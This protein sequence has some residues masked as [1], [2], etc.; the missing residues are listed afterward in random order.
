MIFCP[1]VKELERWLDQHEAEGPG[2]A[3]A[4]HVE[5]CAECQASVERLLNETTP[6]GI[7]RPHDKSLYAAID[8]CGPLLMVLRAHPPGKGNSDGTPLW[9]YGGAGDEATPVVAGYEVLEEI[10]R[11]GMGVVYRARHHSLNRFVALKLIRGGTALEPRMQARFHAEAKAAA[12]LQHPN[13]IQVHEIG[14]CARGPYL[15]LEFVEGGSL[16]GK[17]KG[18]PQPVAE[19]ADMVATLA[20]AIHYAHEQGIIHRDLKPANVLMCTPPQSATPRHDRSPSSSW[21]SARFATLPKI[22]DFGLARL[23]DDQASHSI[24]NAIVGTPSYMAP[25]QA[26]CGLHDAGAST[27]IYSLGAILYEMLTGRPPF[28]GKTSFDTVL[29][30]QHE[31]PIAPRRIRPQLPLDLQTICLKCLRKEPDKRYSSAADVA[32]DLERFLVGRPILARPV[33]RVESCWR[34]CRRNPIVASL[35]VAL[36]LVIVFG[37]VGVSWKW[38]ESD[39]QRRRAM[40]LAEAKDSALQR[41]KFERREKEVALATARINLYFH[42]IALAH[43]EWQANNLAMAEKILDECPRDLRNWEWHYLK[44]RCH[45]ET[46]VLRECGDSVQAIAFSPDGQRLATAAADGTVVVW[47]ARTRLRIHT[48][49]GK[50]GNFSLLRFNLDGNRL[51]RVSK[52]VIQGAPFASDTNLTSWDTQTGRPIFDIANPFV[53]YKLALNNDATR[54]AVVTTGGTTQLW[55]IQ[56]GTELAKL[57]VRLAGACVP[58]ISRDGNLI[59]GVSANGCLLVSSAADGSVVREL[60]RPAQRIV[61]VDF[62]PDGRRLADARDQSVCLWDV[63][64]GRKISETIEPS[65]GIHSVQFAAAGNWLLVRSGRRD[66][67]IQSTNPP[68]K[69]EIART[70]TPMVTAAAVNPDGTSVAIGCPD[71]S[72]R[73]WDVDSLG[74]ARA[75]KRLPNQ[76][77]VCLSPDAAKLAAMDQD[78]IVV[79]DGATGQSLDAWKMVRGAYPVALSHDGRHIVCAERD[80]GFDILDAKSGQEEMKLLGHKNQTVRLFPASGNLVLPLCRK[81]RDLQPRRQAAGRRVRSRRDSRVER[82]DGRRSL[83]REF[84]SNHGSGARVSARMAAGSLSLALAALLK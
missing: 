71:G 3:L 73:L 27:D 53:G 84:S 20:R 9:R 17:I 14:E 10:G 21:S 11:G 33:G 24:G 23:I 72:V 57:P 35:V 82:R 1:S 58:A 49:F 42:S 22:S 45:D 36:A 16:A 30:A 76:R 41:E 81:N 83:Y 80:G 18:I 38:L 60:E 74:G 50:A 5:V 31:E 4:A 67:R 79:R 39:S 64:T 47:D 51:V 69:A 70:N 32:V 66:V 19:S 13:I 78:A 48:M 37:F 2:E 65:S 7:R 62:S 59:A 28:I 12:R 56:T 43:R 8:D 44:R 40:G 55:D 61:S 68:R 6:G 15:A 75:I 34:W 25:E 29:Q 77:F 52:R 46:A 26:D 63:A 54:L